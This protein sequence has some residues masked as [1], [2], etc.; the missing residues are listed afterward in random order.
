MLRPESG[1]ATGAGGVAD[2]AALDLIGLG[3][4]GPRANEL[5]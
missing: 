4:D 5:R 3:N 1:S 2:A